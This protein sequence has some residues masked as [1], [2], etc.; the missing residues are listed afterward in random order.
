[1]LRIV[2][3]LALVALA[4][5]FVRTPMRAQRIVA[6]KMLPLEEMP[7]LIAKASEPIE[8]NPIFAFVLL[9]AAIMGS[10][11][12]FLSAFEKPAPKN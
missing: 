12:G 1:M 3:I 2:L 6:P 8:G 7:M 9:S 11:P 5:A 4:S 10:L